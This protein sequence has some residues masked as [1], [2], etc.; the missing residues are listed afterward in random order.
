MDQAIGDIVYL[1]LI[2]LTFIVLA[3]YDEVQLRKDNK[4]YVFHRTIVDGDKA[5]FYIQNMAIYFLFLVISFISPFLLVF[6]IPFFL[7][8]LI[9]TKTAGYI[10]IYFGKKKD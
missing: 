10:V 6:I 9:I 2:A 7:L 3:I 5:Q 1:S 8:R 4:D